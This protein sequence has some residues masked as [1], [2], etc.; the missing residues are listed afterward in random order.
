MQQ[1]NSERFKLFLTV[2]IDPNDPN[3]K[4][5]IGFVTKDM[6]KK[7]MPAPSADTIILFCGP[8]IFEDMIKGFLTELGYNDDMQFKF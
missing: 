5:G 2:D 3:W 6:L 1:A 8:P 7:H 4:G